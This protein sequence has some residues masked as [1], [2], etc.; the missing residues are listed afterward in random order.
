MGGGQAPRRQD[1]VIQK[2]AKK[3]RLRGGASWLRLP[4]RLSAGER[5]GVKRRKNRKK[6][7]SLNVAVS[8]VMRFSL[9]QKG[10]G[11][12]GTPALLVKEERQPMSSVAAAGSTSRFSDMRARRGGKGSRTKSRSLTT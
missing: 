8:I 4:W 1:K 7:D 5:K 2:Q 3:I 10:G 6:A 12:G 9:V 11:E